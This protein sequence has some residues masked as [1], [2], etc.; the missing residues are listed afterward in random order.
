MAF[1][2][3]KSIWESGVLRFR[4][5]ATRTPIA[6]L[7][8]LRLHPY[9]TVTN[10]D[11]Q[12]NTLSAAQIAGGIVVHT[13]ETGGGTVTLDTAANIIAAFPGIGTGDS[14]KCYYVNDGTEILTLATATGTTIFDAGQ[15]IA[16]NEAAILVILVTSSTTVT[17]YS[18]G[19]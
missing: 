8:T 10:V 15:T 2:L 14:V 1:S 7:G 9:L 11:A 12:D 6:T 3:I 17:V 19:A 4:N 13:S 16:A 18:I 5:K